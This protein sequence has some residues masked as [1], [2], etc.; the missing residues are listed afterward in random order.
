[1]GLTHRIDGGQTPDS[2]L[3]DASAHH[4]RLHES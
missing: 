2:R 1:M 4:G 3:S